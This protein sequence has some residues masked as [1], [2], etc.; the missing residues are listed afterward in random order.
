[1][2]IITNIAV[3][4]LVF[5]FCL[6]TRTVRADL[7]VSGSVSI[8]AKADFYAPLASSGTWI[9][10]GTYGRC[11]RPAGVAV[12]WRPYCAGH[13]VWTDCGW[14]WA[15]DE[16]WGWA[17]Y[18]Y[19]W[20]VYD[21]VYAWIWVP[22]IEWSP[23]WVSWRVGGGYVGWAPLPP[24][25]VS[26]A[27][28]RF[29]FVETTRFTQPLRPSVIVVNNEAVLKKTVVVSNIKTE[30]RNIGGGVHEKVVVNEGPGLA[31]V[32]RATASKVRM[33]A[34]REAARQAR[35]PAGVSSSSHIAPSKDRT[36]TGTREQVRP[37]PAPGPAPA[38]PRGFN[39]RPAPGPAPDHR[40]P[41]AP[42]GRGHG[43]EHEREGKDHGKNS[44][45]DS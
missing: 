27:E 13:W 31:A 36:V 29:V 30:T 10:V 7:E 16:P 15:S 9:E 5:G 6:S 3:A 26:I 14:Y 43:H 19:G 2:K 11:W 32:D 21:P 38:E 42:E 20:W 25:G 41:P 4:G 40:N 12:E 17:C 8:H 35:A 39:P 23:A 37:A 44:S 45:R 24:H 22:G 34:I 33:V 1:M 18:H 28:P